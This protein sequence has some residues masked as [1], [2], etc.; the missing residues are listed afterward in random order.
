METDQ[1]HNWNKQQKQKE[2]IPLFLLIIALNNNNNTNNSLHTWLCIAT[3]F[4]Y[5]RN[6]FHYVNMLYKHRWTLN[7]N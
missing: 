2:K 1:L 6:V 4:T 5:L 7:S 3:Y